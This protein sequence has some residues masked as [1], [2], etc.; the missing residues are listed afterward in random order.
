[1]WINKT[2]EIYKVSYV[3]VKSPS[4]NPKY[5]WYDKSG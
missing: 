4:F 3:K 2:I 1:M 5:A